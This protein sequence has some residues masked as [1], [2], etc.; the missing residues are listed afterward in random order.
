MIFAVR[1]DRSLWFFFFARSKKKSPYFF[2]FFSGPNSSPLL[3]PSFLPSPWGRTTRSFH[4]FLFSAKPYVRGCSSSHLLEDGGGHDSFLFAE[5]KYS[6]G[7]RPSPSRWPGS[8]STICPFSFLTFIELCSFFMFAQRKQFLLYFCAKEPLFFSA[9]PRIL[10]SDCRPL[11]WTSP[12]PL[13]SFK[14]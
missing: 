9:D 12:F 10:P 6:V 7:F 8:Y 1:E 13:L 4:F 14:S 3:H 2:F 11:G 5:T